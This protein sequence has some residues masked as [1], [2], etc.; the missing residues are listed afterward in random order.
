[1][2]QHVEAHE[3]IV[4]GRRGSAMERAGTS[5]TFP[6]VWATDA[7]DEDDILGL[8][9]VLLDVDDDRDR[10]LEDEV[11]LGAAS[12]PVRRGTA[13]PGGSVRS[14]SEQSPSSRAPIALK[15]ISMPRAS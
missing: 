14:M 11:G 4:E 1:M 3:V 7:W 6:N 15:C 9:A 8:E 12:V 2:P 13:S 10:P 5:P